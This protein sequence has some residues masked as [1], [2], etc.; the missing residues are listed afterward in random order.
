VPVKILGR[1]VYRFDG[2]ALN[3]DTRQLMSA[4]AE[5]HLSP[6]AFELLMMLVV[7]RQRAVSKA[8]LQQQLWPSTFVEETNLAG[9]VVELR[10]ALADSASTP[11]FIRTVYG[12]GYRFVAEV[13]EGDARSPGDVLAASCLVIGDRPVILLEGA[14]IVGRAPDATI[15]IDGRGVSRHHARI[16]VSHA[17]ATIEDLGSKNGTLVNGNRV[18]TPVALANGD[19]IRLGAVTLTFRVAPPPSRTE[20]LV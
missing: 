10:H 2:F 18:T 5:V 11:R 4:G 16:H 20:T 6:K 15:S 13:T 12:F 14:N 7:N 9:L 8:E 1:V 19:E 3:A 17:D